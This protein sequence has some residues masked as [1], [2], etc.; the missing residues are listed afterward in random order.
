[1][2]SNL[3]NWQS[4]MY[5]VKQLPPDKLYLLLNRVRR[6]TASVKSDCIIIAQSCSYE[7]EAQLHNAVELE[8]IS[9]Q[10]AEPVLGTLKEL[11]EKLVLLQGEKECGHGM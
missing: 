9:T 3:M 6:N 10:Q 4:A 8:Y 7:I 5:L 11:S 2:T 1:M